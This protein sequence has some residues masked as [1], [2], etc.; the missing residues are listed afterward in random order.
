MALE[1]TIGAPAYQPRIVVVGAPAGEVRA[2]A[3]FLV[4]LAEGFP[5]PTVLMV[6]GQG[7][8]GEGD[9]EGVDVTL[10]A[11]CA[12]PVRQIDDK[13][14]I[15]PGRVHVAPRG[16][17]LLVERGHF[18]LSTEPPVNGARP[19][20]DVLL[21]SAADAFGGAVVCALLGA[22]DNAQWPRDGHTGAERV[23]ACGGLVI[24]QNPS[25]AAVTDEERPQAPVALPP[26]A[27]M[28]H[29][30]EIGPFV[31][32]LGEAEVS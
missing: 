25:T 5:L 29:L 18:V 15:L 20:M 2:A 19:S 1:R 17:H 14:P 28:L 10:Q 9:A 27:T 13:D 32:R 8:G 23:R 4:G 7:E 24:I 6:S 11:H 3:M 21:E 12:L 26:A 30:S 22:D 16:Y 31:S